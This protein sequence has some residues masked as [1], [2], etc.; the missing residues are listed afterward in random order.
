MSVE[1][2]QLDAG[3]PAR[4]EAAIQAS[5]QQTGKQQF[6]G[7]AT[8][9]ALAALVLSAA[10]FAYQ[11]YRDRK[12]DRKTDPDV[13]KRRLRLALDDRGYPDTIQRDRVIEAAVQ[14]IERER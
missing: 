1:L 10:Q 2:T 3:L 11:I 7:G 9:V 12:Q 5:E 6:D 14:I 8:A 4:L 13:L